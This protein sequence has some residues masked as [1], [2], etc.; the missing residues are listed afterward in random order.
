[1][2]PISVQKPRFRK[3]REVMMLDDAEM[4][5]KL[6]DLAQTTSL[7]DSRNAPLPP[8]QI[9]YDFLTELCSAASMIMDR[10]ECEALEKEIAKLQPLHSAAA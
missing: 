10:E 5:L 2:R 8:A 6:T 3:S 9:P 7:K 1:M 4:A